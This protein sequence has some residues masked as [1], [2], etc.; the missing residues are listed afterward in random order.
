MG[1]LNGDS[2]PDIVF[3]SSFFEV[4]AYNL[5]GYLFPGFPT[6]AANYEYRSSSIGKLSSS[7]CIMAMGGASDTN[8]LDYLR[9]FN[10]A[11][12]QLPWSPLRPKGIPVSAVTFGDINNDK[13]I[14]FL[15]T[16]FGIL[17]GGDNSGLYAW[18]VPGIN[19]LKEDFPW[20]MYC[21]DRYRS[22]QYGFVPPDEPV[23]IQ[24]ISSI[25]PEK[26]LLYQNY[27]NPFNPITKI[28]FDIPKYTN[29]DRSNI[30]LIVFDVLGREVITLLNEKLN[31]GSYQV[32]FDGS[33]STSG[34]YY[35]SLE[36]GNYR[37]T[38]KFILLK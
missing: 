23:G 17:I 15:I 32:T 36:I 33:N 16:T 31:E 28:K 24:P 38:K 18:T 13:Q 8:N 14:D 35:Y 21:H 5:N 29:R 11:G 1:D 27:P 12:I 26:F 2:I 20:P 30:R 22:N 10:N 4:Y 34:V 19:Y 6:F 37:E 25:V 9:A 7:M 3:G